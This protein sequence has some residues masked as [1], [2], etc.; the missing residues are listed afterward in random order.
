MDIIQE[1]LVKLWPEKKIDYETSLK[2]SG[3]FKG[4][5][6]NIRLRGNLL[7]VN[8]GKQWRHVSREIQLGLVQSLLSRLFKQKTKSVNIDLYNIFMKNV[9]I[10]IPKTRTHPVLE[11]S[12][13]KIN[14]VFFAGIVEK[15]NLAWADS[16]R[17]LG[18]YDYST[19]TISISRILSSRQDLLDYVMYHEVLHKKHKFNTK[20][21]R[22]YH[23]TT[24]F[25][26]NERAFPNAE[27]LEKD[28]GKLVQRSSLRKIF[29][30]F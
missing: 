12:F 17:K 24:E 22:Q 15:P 11:E 28:L 10:A 6:A 26:R 5:N 9:H 14:Q 7:T 30:W 23:H 3:K 8:L 4:Y 29:S 20:N 27:E 18:S 21:G 25:R 13:D 16:V 1:A 2:Y 19:D